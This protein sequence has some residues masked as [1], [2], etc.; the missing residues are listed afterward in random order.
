[1]SRV[2]FVLMLLASVAFDGIL[3]TPW[4]H[5]F[6]LDLNRSTGARISVDESLTL[7]LFVVLVVVMFAVFGGFAAMVSRAGGHQQNFLGALATLLPSLAPISFGYLL[8]HNIDNLSINGQLLIPLA[9]NPSGRHQWL[10]APFTD[11]YEVRL[12]LIPPALN[13]Y[14]AVVVIVVVHVLAVVVAHRY[15]AQAGSTLERARR[16]EY[17]WIVA[18]VAYTMVA[19]GCLP[20]R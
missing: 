20:S 12:K 15:L 13:W 10:P 2:V 16:S 17:P 9:G 5:R 7:L 6:N 19:C 4:W 18:M 14:L 11:A 1:M 3:S 8:A